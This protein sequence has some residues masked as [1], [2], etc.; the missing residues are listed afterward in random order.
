M[1]DRILRFLL[2]VMHVI[3]ICFTFLATRLPV[4]IMRV[5]RNAHQTMRPP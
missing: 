2:A 5:V 1:R 4:W 3:F